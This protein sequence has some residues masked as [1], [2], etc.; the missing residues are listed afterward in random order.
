[1]SEVLSQS[2]IDSLLSALSSGSIDAN[3]LKQEQTK[4]KVKVYDFRRPNKFSK[5]QIHTLH[6][7]FDN[8][9]RSLGTYLSAQL[10]SLIHI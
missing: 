9:T 4:K 5:D 1:M 2:E 6:V 8:Y 10:L 3:E 7:I